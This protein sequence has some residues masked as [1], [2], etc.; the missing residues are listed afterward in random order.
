MGPN[1][2]ILEFGMEDGHCSNHK[3]GMIHKCVV[4]RDKG[5]KLHNPSW[6]FEFSGK[7]TCHVYSLEPTIHELIDNLRMGIGFGSV[8]TWHCL[9]MIR[10]SFTH[11]L[12]CQYVFLWNLNPISWSWFSPERLN[13]SYL[14]FHS[15]VVF[16]W[17]LHGYHMHS[18]VRTQKRTALVKKTISKSGKKQ[19]T[20]IRGALR[21]SASYPPGF[22]FALAALI[23]PKGCP[24]QS[25]DRVG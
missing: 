13:W 7:L 8:T 20:G 5:V 4:Y 1:T 3:P 17:F 10:T 14:Q 23:Q 16:P 6:V 11:G 25:L 18:F 12:Y 21:E 9:Y 24:A 19:V 2:Q 15:E 22:G